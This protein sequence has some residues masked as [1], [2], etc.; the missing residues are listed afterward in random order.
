MKTTNIYNPSY[1]DEENQIVHDCIKN[2]SEKELVDLIRELQK[3][4]EP[5]IPY[6][7]TTIQQL[8]KELIARDI[9]NQKYYE[10]LNCKKEWKK[11][12]TKLVNYKEALIVHQKYLDYEKN[13]YPK[14]I[15]Q[16]PSRDKRELFYEQHSGDKDFPPIC[17]S[18]VKNATLSSTS[19]CRPKKPYA[20]KKYYSSINEI[21]VHPLNKDESLEKL[22]KKNL[23]YMLHFMLYNIDSP[24]AINTPVIISF[25]TRKYAATNH[26]TS[27]Q[28]PLFTTNIL[29]TPELLVKNQEL[30][31]ELKYIKIECNEL[32]NEV[33]KIEKHQ[34]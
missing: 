34:Q 4:Y 3:L 15:Q 2:A 32:L 9:L 24:E 1:S 20:P 12:S 33:E 26:K 21:P 10:L 17:E 5:N 29:S 28:L 8:E 18:K 13:E 22:G 30:I 25:L 14:L 27:K 11:Y 19:K 16:Y 7:N 6:I 23:K 31:S